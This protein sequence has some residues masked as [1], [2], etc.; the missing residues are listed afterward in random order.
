MR[1]NE[2]PPDINDYLE[3]VSDDA[4]IDVDNFE[5]LIFK[6]RAQTGLEVNSIKIL[7]KTYFQ[8]IRN[9]MLKGNKVILNKI[10]K[11]KITYGKKTFVNFKANPF[12]I[13]KINE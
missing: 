1:K 8:E 13:S 10:G 7:L 12:I 9:Q 6:I 4:P 2:L 5:E 11:F 3:Q